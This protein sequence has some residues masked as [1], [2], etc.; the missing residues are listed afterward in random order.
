MHAV[1]LTDNKIQDD[2]SYNKPF[3]PLNKCKV[4]IILDRISHQ[5]GTEL[6]KGNQ[7]HYYLGGQNEMER[8]VWTFEG[9][10][11]QKKVLCGN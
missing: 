3:R 7:G 9:F 2:P 4:I 6:M 1:I 5:A 10:F 11:S 8:L